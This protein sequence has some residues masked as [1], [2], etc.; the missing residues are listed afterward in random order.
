[1]TLLLKGS[2][3]ALPVGPGT[4]PDTRRKRLYTVHEAALYLAVSDDLVYGLVGDGVLPSVRLGKGN[5]RKGRVL[6][7]RADLDR[8]IDT[9][10]RGRADG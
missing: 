8:L 2:A 1:M 7:D 6:I 9:L 5:Q 4:E 3:L 10:K